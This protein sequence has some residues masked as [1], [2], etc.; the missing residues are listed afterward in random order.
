MT[1]ELWRSVPL[2]GCE[3]YEVSDLGR[4]RKK[5]KSGN[6]SLINGS[7]K[8]YVECSLKKSTIPLHRLVLL[9]F[10]APFETNIFNNFNS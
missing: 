8:E 3:D 6:Y 4:L 1:T 10:V 7:Q 2:E 9:A 5:R